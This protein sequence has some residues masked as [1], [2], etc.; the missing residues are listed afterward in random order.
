MKVKDLLERLKGVNP[1]LEVSMR[2][3]VEVDQ[4]FEFDESEFIIGVKEGVEVLN[5]GDI[6]IITGDVHLM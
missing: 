6:I 5:F 3:F 2:V 1:D 4:S